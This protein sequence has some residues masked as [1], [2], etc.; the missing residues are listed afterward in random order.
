M[1]L[2]LEICG[3]N[4]KKVSIGHELKWLSKCEGSLQKDK[5][6]NTRIR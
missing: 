6:K 3:E 1:I 4:P 2:R 5:E